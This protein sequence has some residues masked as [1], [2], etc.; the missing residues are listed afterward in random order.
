MGTREKGGY[1]QDVT[2]DCALAGLFLFDFLPLDDEKLVRTIQAVEERLWVD[3]PV[4]GYARYEDDYY[5][6]VSREIERIPGNPWFV[7]T[8]WIA[9][10]HAR[11]AVNRAGLAPAFRCLDWAR[12]HARPSGVMAEQV[13]PESGEPLSVAPLTWSH[14]A[15]VSAALA[16]ARKLSELPAG[17]DAAGSV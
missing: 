10:W 11:R 1:W 13:H 6:Q 3:T 7:C 14:A 2:V 9:E 5:H 8:L 12:Q 4:G 17:P 15:Y 16:V